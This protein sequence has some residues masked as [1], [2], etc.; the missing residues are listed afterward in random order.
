MSWPEALA[1]IEA[2]GRV[3]RAGWQCHIEMGGDGWW[4]V[5]AHTRVR[6][7][8]YAYDR[9]AADWELA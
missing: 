5:Y 7:R 8:Q 2:G 1:I 6:Y 9:K 4:C 3:R